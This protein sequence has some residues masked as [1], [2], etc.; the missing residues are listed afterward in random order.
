MPGKFQVEITAVAETDVEEIWEYNAQDTIDAA[1]SLVL[2]LEEQIGR[3]EIF[4]LRCPIA[5]ENELL[6]T[7][8]R[9]LLYGKYRIIFRIIDSRVII[10]R[11]LHTARLLDTEMP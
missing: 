3:L 2:H 10:M 6:G 5:P 11:V 8:Y 9:H 1:N 4:P 7:S